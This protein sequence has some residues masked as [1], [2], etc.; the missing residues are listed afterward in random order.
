VIFSALRDRIAPGFL[1]K[2]DQPA[3]SKTPNI[4]ALPKR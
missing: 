2:A 3:A 1:R 4:I